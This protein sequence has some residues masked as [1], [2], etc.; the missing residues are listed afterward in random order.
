MWAS[1]VAVQTC[2]H[3]WGLLGIWAESRQEYVGVAM[4]LDSVG[5]NKG[6]LA[7]WGLDYRVAVSEPHSLERGQ[8]DSMLCCLQAAIREPP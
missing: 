4:L 7:F 1:V 6:L 2:K 5:L 3:W 8:A